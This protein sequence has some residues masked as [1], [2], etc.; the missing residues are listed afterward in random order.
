[1]FKRKLTPG[2]L[3]VLSLLAMTSPLATDMYLASFT[4]IVTD[5]GT[6]A[7]AVQ[8]TLTT[9]LLG[10]GLGQLFFGPMSDRFG[11]RPVLLVA[12]TILVVDSVALI[13][14][15]N[16][17][18]LIVLRFIQ[19]FMGAA[20]VVL[21]RAIAADVSS[22]AETVRALSLIAT[23][24]GLGPLLAPVI[25]GFV[26][27]HAGWRAVFAVLA[28]LT[29]LMLVLSILLIPETLPADKR[30]VGSLLSAYSSV[31]RLALDRIFMGY[32][33]TFSMGFGAMMAYISASPFV[34]QLI[35]GMNQ[36]QYGLSFAMG[37][38]ALILANL[39]NAKV[40]AS[41]GPKRMQIV[42]VS[43]AL[44][45][46]LTM[47]L[48]VVTGSLSIP[49]FIACAFFLTGGVGLIMSNSSALAL[50]RASEARGSGSAL[51]GAGQFFV[52]GLVSPLVGLGGG[53]TAVPMALVMAAL[54][55]TA[56]TFAML[57]RWARGKE[58]RG[59][60]TKPPQV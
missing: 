17:Y 19:G 4:N 34:G 21:S 29:M 55:I 32:V 41:V 56:F 57:N 22:G 37:A 25:G 59:E 7:P 30:H 39:L 42:G 20:G 35:L 31:G 54:V 53:T 12:L 2:F 38:A 9:F 8:L 44:A 51:L 18:L 16:V 28:S 1:M 52:G 13:F 40:A 5:L 49:V 36:I 27:Q 47:L 14:A 3:A 26:S 24:V 43:L 10:I 46:G 33:I 45:A 11:R 58:G 15:P 50:E 6:T 23:L 60:W 48:V